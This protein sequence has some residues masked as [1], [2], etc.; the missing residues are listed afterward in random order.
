MK[1][2]NRLYWIAGLLALTAQ[3]VVLA[4]GGHGHGHGHHGHGHHGHRH[5]H[6]NFGISMGGFA[7][8]FYGSSFY[9]YGYSAYPGPFFAPPRYGYSPVVTAPVKP[10]VYIQREQTAAAQPSTNYW[11]YCR[12]PE[13]YYPSVKNCP[14]GWIQVA[15]QPLAP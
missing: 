15:P 3:D 8:G 1:K 4:R 14:E 13:G 12:N 9:P 7:P 2:L 10:P 6:F 5:S 11:H